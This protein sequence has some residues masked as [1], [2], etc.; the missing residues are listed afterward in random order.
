MFPRV[1]SRH[2]AYPFQDADFATQVDV[3]ITLYPFYTTKKM[4]DV[5]VTVANSIFP[6][7]NFYTEQMFVLVSMNFLRLS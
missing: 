2:F 3:R 4:P 6:L 7:P 1:Q 5:T